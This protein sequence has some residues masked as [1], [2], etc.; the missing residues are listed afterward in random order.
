MKL[1][2]E[3]P[4]PEPEL[5]LFQQRPVSNKNDI[6]RDTND[7]ERK[8]RGGPIAEALIQNEQMFHSLKILKPSPSEIQKERR[9][10]MPMTEKDPTDTSSK[11]KGKVYSQVC[12]HAMQCVCL[13]VGINVPNIFTFA[14][15]WRLK[16]QNVRVCRERKWLLVF[17]ICLYMK[18]T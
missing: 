1:E 14:Y 10:P 5:P 15:E 6:R 7:M 8:S 13:C 9:K 18:S 11:R 2:N 16:P 12:I 17:L 3:S 4:E